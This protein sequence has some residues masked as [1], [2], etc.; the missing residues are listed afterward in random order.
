[1]VIWPDLIWVRGYASRRHRQSFGVV[2]WN[3]HVVSV[4]SET[5]QFC[6]AALQRTAEVGCRHGWQR[7][8]VVGMVL[9]KFVWRSVVGMV[10]DFLDCHCG[11]GHVLCLDA[12][13][14]KAVL[15]CLTFQRRLRL[16]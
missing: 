1:M 7:R 10:L 8:S 5:L 9:W 16:V 4:V 3:F 11:C 2:I 12:W 15:H 13:F 14:A 6:R